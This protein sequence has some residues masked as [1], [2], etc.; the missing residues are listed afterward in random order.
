MPQRSFDFVIVGAGIVGLTVA[1]ELAKR[2]PT[3]SLAILEKEPAPGLH[4]SGRNSGVMHC[5]IYY[6]RDTLKAKLCAD[7]ARRMIAFAEEEGIAVKRCGKVIIATEKAQLPIVEKLMTNAKDN[8]ITAERIDAQQLREIEP[9]ANPGVA[10]IYCPDTAVIDSAAVIR[11]IT[12]K[13]QQHG[14][15]FFFNT[16]FQRV[17][18]KGCIQTIQSETTQGEFNYGYLVNCAGAYAD[19]VAKAYGLAQEYALAPFKGIYWKLSQ[20]ANPKVRANIYPVPDVS[21]PFLGVHLTRVINGEVYVGPTAIPAFG[22][23]NYGLVQGMSLAESAAIG[24]QL[25]S[26]YLRNENNFRKLA[27]LEMGKY[28]KQN[29]LQAARKLMP[30]LAAKDMASTSKVGIRPQLVNTQT[31]KLEMDYILASTAESLHVLNAISPAFTSSLVFAELIA[32]K[33]DI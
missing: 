2:H 30:S 7:G 29:F 5:G 12:D 25:I 17:R 23:E 26:M 16:A 28:W 8:A 14:A 4:A 15:T 6:G 27:H 31:R 22:R 24:Y 32:D 1:S 20:T 21:M 18:G 10:A 9:Y 11:R 19:V 13:L 3:A 33:L